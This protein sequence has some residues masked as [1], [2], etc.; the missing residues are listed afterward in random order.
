MSET[1]YSNVIDN[2]SVLVGCAQLTDKKGINGYNYLEILTEVSKLAIEDCKSSLNLNE[3]L[4]TV[5]VIRFVADTP[6]RD[7]ATS[8]LWGYPNMPRSLANSLNFSAS[9]ELYTTTGGNS[10]QIVLNEV[11]NRIK[12]KQIECALLAGG[13]ALDTFVSRLKQGLEVNWE[14]DPGGEPELLGKSTD[15]TNDHEKLHGIFD[16][17]S[18]YPLFANALRA[19]NNQTV[20]EHMQ[21][22]A[23]LFET[24]SKVA[25]ENKY[26]WFPI[27]RSAEE[28]AKVEPQNRMIGLPYTKYMNSIMRVNQS[29]A[30]IMMSAKKARELGIPES[31][32]VFMYSGMCLNDIWNMSDR[33]NY[34]SS[35][36]IKACTDSVFELANIT[37][38]DID[39]IDLYSCFPSAVQIAMKELSLEK[40]DKRGL[41]ITGGLPYFG[42][43]GNAYVM[44]SIAS[45][46]DKLRLNPE[47]FGIATANGWYITKH[48]AGIFSTKPFEGEWNQAPDSSSI[49]ETIESAKKPNFTETPEGK[50]SIETYTVL[51]S[52]N[53]P[54]KAI[55][56]GR[57]ENGTRFL[58]NT[59]KN[60][61]ILDYMS[62]NEMLNTL[63][64]V[65]RE[66][67]RN[68]FKPIQEGEINERN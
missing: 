7:S 21:D 68:I 45:M 27:H 44:N 4:D 58:A 5:A 37:I 15:G 12:D 6:H 13:E 24:F 8:N 31:K 50:A 64:Y 51:H 43:P 57:L 32:W 52:R 48:G 22:T 59:E 23:E 67:K 54:D 33:V 63:G 14:D 47:K 40:D 3:H 56:I 46:M 39:F 61:S 29:S 2:T 62:K 34:H 25:S 66:G 49:Q 10:P 30:M 28:I 11:A 60:S 41:T 42:G 20:Q 18:V 17:S 16:P 19:V 55:V 53:G 38:D 1:K 9:N 65:S 26:S 36:A 35:P